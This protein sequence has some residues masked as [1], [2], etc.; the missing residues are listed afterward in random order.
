ME[1]RRVT[2]SADSDAEAEELVSAFMC[3]FSNGKITEENAGIEGRGDA[4][5]W[6]RAEQCHD[7]GYGLAL[8]EPDGEP[9]IIAVLDFHYVD[10]EKG[11]VSIIDVRTNREIAT[12]KIT[13][14]RLRLKS[15]FTG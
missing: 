14:E 3:R 12:Q 4:D 15:K 8:C 9:R 2:I 6:A 13:L 11:E 10:L 1:V 7:K 5:F